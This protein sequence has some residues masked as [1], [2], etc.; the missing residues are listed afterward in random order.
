M[1]PAQLFA[2]TH[3]SIIALWDKFASNNLMFGGVASAFNLTPTNLYDH[4]RLADMEEAVAS[5]MK[6]LD[7]LCPGC[8]GNHLVWWLC[9]GAAAFWADK[10]S[11]YTD[12]DLYVHCD[13][14]L[15]NVNHFD[16]HE[17]NDHRMDTGKVS[18]LNMTNKFHKVQIIP[19]DFKIQQQ[20]SVPAFEDFLG[21]YILASFDLPACRVAIKFQIIPPTKTEERQLHGKLLDLT[22][23][24]RQDPDTTVERLEKYKQ[25]KKIQPINP[26]KLSL[27]V[28]FLLLHDMVRTN[29]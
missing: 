1:Y 28:P 8:T 13:G 18:V 16:L 6:L 19:I 25:R 10:T 21:L 20:T 29:A 23:I 22:Y 4:M 2:P 11:T 3:P 5:A 7:H 27:T 12:Y 15:K 14:M 24:N 9:G 26:G 17:V